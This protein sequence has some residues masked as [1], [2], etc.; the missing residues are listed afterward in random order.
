LDDA[1]DEIA[2]LA[3]L[4]NE[5]KRDAESLIR[6][7]KKANSFVEVDNW[8]Q[9]DGDSTIVPSKAVVPVEFIAPQ[10]TEKQL[11]LILC[12]DILVL[13]Q[14]RGEDWDGSVDLFS[15]LRMST[16]KEPASIVHGR[17]LRVVDNKVN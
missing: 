15:V 9:M 8:T 5:E 14:P 3:S 12:S 4:M 11:V 16:T 2:G 7:V 6:V 17:I 1:L 10:P 13:V